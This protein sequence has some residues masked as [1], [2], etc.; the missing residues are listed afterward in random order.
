VFVREYRADESFLQLPFAAQAVRSLGA[1]TGRVALGL[2]VATVLLA[3][4][5][6]LWS[7]RA[8]RAGRDGVG[9]PRARARAFEAACAA[10]TFA[11]LLLSLAGKPAVELLHFSWLQAPLA[12]AAAV[13]VTAA[14]KWRGPALA[15]ALGLLPL[16]E[17]AVRCGR[18]SYFWSRTDSQL[19]RENLPVLLFEPE[20][21][22]AHRRPQ[23]AK[24]LALEHSDIAPF[25]NRWTVARW[26]EGRVWASMGVVPA[27]SAPLPLDSSWIFAN[28]PV[29]PNNDRQVALPA[30]GAVSRVV[31][32]PEPAPGL[33]LG[34]RCGP[35]PT[36]VSL[37]AGGRRERVFLRP[38]EWRVVALDSRGVRRGAGD[39]PVTRFTELAMRSGSGPAVVEVLDAPEAEEAFRLWSGGDLP[40]D[41]LRAWA[42]RMRGAAE[43]VSR[44]RFVECAGDAAGAAAGSR[45]PAT[46]LSTA[47]LWIPAG[48]YRFQMDIE[49]AAGR[50]AAGEVWVGGA[51]AQGPAGCRRAFSVTNGG[52]ARV[53]FPVVKP[54]EPY[55]GALW[56]RCLHG[57]VRVRSWR[58]RADLDGMAADL[59][60]WAET[61]ARPPWAGAAQ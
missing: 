57:A 10:G 35:E 18:E 58:L 52:C 21:R 22:A 25:R 34:I 47:P 5:G 46:A 13:A 49:A 27:P 19:E 15:S 6:A 32:S 37:G 45:A 39:G 51:D 53:E 2:G 12:L 3:V 9:D 33:R 56:M 11:A 29:L 41:R 60:L 23:V 43:M 59:D 42:G 38:H 54:L 1:N 20:Y 26:P 30:Y 40:A 36:D 16:A 44:L 50:A 61:G 28:G 7:A 24:S 17:G 4:A 8:A 14:R 48:R 31:V 55:G